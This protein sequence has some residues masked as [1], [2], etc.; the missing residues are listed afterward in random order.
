MREH[1]AM[2]AHH[3]HLVPSL[4]FRA[5]R[6]IFFEGFGRSLGFLVSLEMT[7]RQAIFKL[8]F[9]IFNGWFMRIGSK[10][11][12]LLVIFIIV[13]AGMVSA[14]AFVLVQ[15]VSDG[16]TIVL[17]DG[18]RVRYIGINSPELAKESGPAERSYGR[19]RDRESARP[20]RSRR[21]TPRGR[22][23]AP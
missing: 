4:S 2:R 12:L 18:R 8:Q 23:S 11:C 13:L 19:S 10:L 16:D 5:K 15:H 20:N 7:D 22:T 6:E 14:K 3:S 1:H 9:S 17:S 21:R